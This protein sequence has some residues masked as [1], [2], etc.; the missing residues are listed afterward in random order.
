MRPILPPDLFDLWS[1]RAGIMEY[2]ANL[3]REI[4]ANA[5]RKLVTPAE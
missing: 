5:L 2:D 4:A 1:E 3:P